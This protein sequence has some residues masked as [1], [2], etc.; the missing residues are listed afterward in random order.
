MAGEIGVPVPLT[1]NPALTDAP[2]SGPFPAIVKPG[3]KLGMDRLSIEK[4]WRVEG[5]TDLAVRLHDAAAVHDPATLM[6]Q[7]L[8]PGNGEEQF[9]FAGLCVNGEPLVFLVTQ[10]LRQYP[11]DF[12]RSSTYVVTADDSQVEALATRIISHLKLSGLVEVEFKR[13]ARDGQYKLLDV[14]AR[15]WGWHTIG[16]GVGADFPYLQWRLLTGLPIAR[17]R[18]PAGLRWMRLSTD[19]AASIPAIRQGQLSAREYV[20]TLIGRH[21]RAVFAWDDA[22][23]GFLDAP[24]AGVQAVTTRLRQPQR[25]P[26][27]DH[28]LARARQHAAAHRRRLPSQPTKGSAGESV[29][30]AGELGG[31]D[32]VVVPRHHVPGGLDV[33]V[34][35]M[36]DERQQFGGALG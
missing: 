29:E 4:A 34:P 32:V 8:I 25:Q 1:A 9:S 21:E 22:L 28:A 2:Y 26:I 6:V 5:T 16:R 11:M 3:V 36:R 35:S 24:L 18:V 19:V 23:P 10:R 30:K 12:G 15:I 7:E 31:E 14:N 17:R 33:D 27:L 20:A 13:D